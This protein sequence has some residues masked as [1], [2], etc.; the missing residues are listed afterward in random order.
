MGYRRPENQRLANHLR[1]KQDALCSFLHC[2][3]LDATNWRAEQAIRP[4]VV[5]RQKCG[6]QSHPSWSKNAKH[7]GQHPANLPTTRSAQYPGSPP[8][9]V[10]PQPRIL[11]L[12]T[13]TR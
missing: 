12:T 10:L 9:A 7:P 2:P 3:G 5:T 11:D 1:R 8:I 6:R 4:M 13:P